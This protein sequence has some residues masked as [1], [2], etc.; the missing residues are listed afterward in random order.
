MLASSVTKVQRNISLHFFILSTKL[1]Q[2]LLKYV[3][4][5][6]KPTDLTYLM[7]FIT[8]VNRCHMF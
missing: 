3:I 7:Y 1:E 4:H 5:Q 6:I 8:C 2:M